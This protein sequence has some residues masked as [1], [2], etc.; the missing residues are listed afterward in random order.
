[1]KK[2]N[3]LFADDMIL[4]I[5][6]PKYST[7]KLLEIINEYDKDAGCTINTQ[8]SLAF[9]YTN[10]VKTE[11][12][13]IKEREN[14]YIIV[15]VYTPKLSPRLKVKNPSATKEITSS[16]HGMGR[17]PGRGHGNPLQYCFLENPHGQRSLVACNP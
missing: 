16:I 6:N 14:I 5:E 17:F 11:R 10:N 2:K 7:R 9:L 12:R 8:T 15:S 4:Y 1:M 3:S 13:K